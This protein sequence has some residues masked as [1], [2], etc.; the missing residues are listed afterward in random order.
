[1]LS[2]CLT[3]RRFNNKFPIRLEFHRYLT[4]DNICLRGIVLDPSGLEEPFCTYTT[5]TDRV[6]PP[7]QVALKTYAEGEGADTTLI[8]ANII[9]PDPVD[10]I[11]SG[12][13]IIP[14]YKLT[15]SAKK[16]FSL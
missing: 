16:A 2:V 14:V 5:N 13:V 1:M 7:D 6:L 8:A 9:E 4:N 12:W 11:G 15:E 10:F 3:D